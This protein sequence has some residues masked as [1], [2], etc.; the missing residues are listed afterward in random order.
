MAPDRRRYGMRE[1]TSATHLLQQQ[2]GLLLLLP[3]SIAPHSQGTRLN[4]HG[5]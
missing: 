5:R 2:L 1:M 3:S 4:T